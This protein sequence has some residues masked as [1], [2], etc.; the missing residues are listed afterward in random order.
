MEIYKP[1]YEDLWFRKEMLEDDETMSYNHLWGGAISFPEDKWSDWYNYWVV[2]HDD[3][4]FYRYVKINDMF[5]GEIAYHYDDELNGFIANVLIYAKYRGRGYGWQAL[6]MLC[7]VAKNNGI[8]TLYDD[9]AI[10]N[11]AISLFYKQDFKEI[12]RTDE[13]II[14]KKDL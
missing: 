3:K 5:V 1:E 8:K 10:D 4:R 13:K 6:E 11:P 12:Y 7:S 9:I 14:L 2:N